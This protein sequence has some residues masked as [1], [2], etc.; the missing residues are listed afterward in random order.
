MPDY[1]I[2]KKALSPYL[3][4]HGNSSFTVIL[5][6]I[7]HKSLKRLASRFEQ[8]FVKYPTF[9]NVLSTKSYLKIDKIDNR[10]SELNIYLGHKYLA[11]NPSG[12]HY[13]STSSLDNCKT[14]AERR[15]VCR[16]IIV[17]NSDTRPVCELQILLSVSN[18][19]PTICTTT[20]FAAHINTFQRLENNRWLYILSNATQ[21]ILQCNNQVS[22]HN[23][24]GSGIITL[25]TNCK[26]HTGY[27]TLSA[28]QIKE[29][30]IT[31]PI[32]V[33]DIR[34]EDCFEETEDHHFPNLLPISINENP[35]DSL[36]NLKHQLDKHNEEIQQMKQK[37]FIQRHQNRFSWFY[38]T[39]GTLML[40]FLMYKLFRRCLRVANN[41]DQQLL[42]T[43]ITTTSMDR[44][45]SEHPDDHVE[46][47]HNVMYED[48]SD[49]NS[50]TP[51]RFG[52]NAQSLF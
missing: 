16:D 18:D 11:T 32:I 19:I 49:D 1:F 7:A 47:N 33:L 46:P 30:N 25:E 2:K 43:N 20:T 48:D 37:P 3:M 45:H 5:N 21:C 36:N 15:S 40:S 4:T 29:D 10:L 50:S 12:E 14:Y 8:F 9:P 13:V 31:F 23:I 51:K 6:H 52:A 24:Y 44:S 39:T 22:H 35:L 28:H 41:F 38:F 42:R 34:T 17:Y 26:L 27:S